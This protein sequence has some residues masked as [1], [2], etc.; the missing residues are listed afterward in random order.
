MKNKTRSFNPYDYLQP[1]KGGQMI[2]K[3]RGLLALCLVI[4]L[5][6][7]FSIKNAIAMGELPGPAPIDK[8]EN[9]ILKNQLT[10]PVSLVK[11]GT[12]IDPTHVR[13]GHDDKNIR[14]VIPLSTRDDFGPPVAP[15]NRSS[16]NVKGKDVQLFSIQFKTSNGSW[17]SFGCKKINKE[18]SK[19]ITITITDS[20][21]DRWTCVPNNACRPCS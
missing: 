16:I 1:E 13:T 9:I 3:T 10:R 14:L 8:I 17:E 12:L 7:T 11:G 19:T 21:F 4:C 18:V 15:N 6:C 2:N 5:V 20:N